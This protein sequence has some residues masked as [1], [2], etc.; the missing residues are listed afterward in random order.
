MLFSLTYYAEP[1]ELAAAIIGEPNTHVTVTMNSPISLHCYAWGW[2]RP[3]VTW[4]Q[5][6][7]MLP[8]ISELYE[9]DS[10]YTLLIRSVTLPTLGVYTCQAFNAIGRAASWSV[11]LQAVGPVYNVKPEYEKYLKYLVDPPRKHE[12]PQYPHRPN[13][14]QTSDSHTYGPAYTTRQFHVPTASPIGYTTLDY[15]TKFRGERVIYGGFFLFFFFFSSF[16]VSSLH[17]QDLEFV[18]SLRR[19]RFLCFSVILQ[20]KIVILSVWYCLL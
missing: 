20:I 6:D 11:T 7:R 14:T 10:E 12:R 3:F 13:R 18:Q 16:R 8:L 5:G 4:W 9:Q 17:C 2:P 19:R 1:K 15:G